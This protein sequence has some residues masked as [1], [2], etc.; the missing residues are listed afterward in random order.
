[1][2]PLNIIKGHSERG[3]PPNIG[4][5]ESTH[6]YTLDRK[7]P[8][9]ENKVSTQRTKPAGPEGVLT[10]RFHCNCLVKSFQGPLHL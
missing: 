6:V 5:A 3:Q 2:K 8:L 1:M 9:K 10:K 7:S 4:Q